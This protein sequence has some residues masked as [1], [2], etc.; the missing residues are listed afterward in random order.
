LGC[1]RATL[2]ATVHTTT[3]VL[4]KSSLS[5]EIGSVN[6]KFREFCNLKD[7]F[8]L[9]SYGLGQAVIQKSAQR[10]GGVGSLVAEGALNIP[11]HEF[12]LAG[13][14]RKTHTW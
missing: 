10:V 4:L 3:S 6:V 7:T 2:F 13:V 9:L 14:V 12:G 5:C 11:D 1:L 8:L